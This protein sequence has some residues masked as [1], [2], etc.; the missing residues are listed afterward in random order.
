MV[1]HVDRWIDGYLDH[2]RVE[3]GLG[4]RTISAYAS[5]LG[6]FVTLL[7]ARG[8]AIDS[9]DLGAISGVL[10]ELSTQGRSARS[11]ARFL[12]SLRGLYKYLLQE[13][14]LRSSPMEL[15]EAP[16]IGRKLPS[17]LS[18]DEVL[19]LLVAADLSEP[20]GQR[21]AA[22]IHTMY[23]AG[24]R[25]S[26]LVELGLGDV[27]LRA[28]FLAAF[29][30]GRKRRLLPLGELARDSLARYLA[31]VRGLW[32][33]PNEKRLFV[34]HRRAPM[35]RQGFWKLLKRYGRAAGITKN[36]TPHMLRH[37]FATHL[38]EGG[39]DLR[40]V[41]TLLGHADI[42]TTQIYTHVSADRLASMHQRYHPRGA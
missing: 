6:Q 39:A 41:Q 18:R 40:I 7:A 26:E 42:S 22:M 13:G 37:S 19:R 5:D 34:T 21:D 4:A 2:L 9:A 20:R 38:L 14:A 8:Y 10:V 25:V 28:G 35:T 30:K 23:A 32:A 11:Q 15:V 36:L 31:S 16:R 12:S 27:D 3:R 29:G 24:L 17:L 1:E 33:K